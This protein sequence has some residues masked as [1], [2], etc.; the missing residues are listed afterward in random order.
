MPLTLEHWPAHLRGTAW[1]D[2][3]RLLVG[4]LLSSL[5]FEFVCTQL[6]RGTDLG[7]RWM[8]WIGILPA[9]LVFFIMR[10]VKEARCGS[11]ASNQRPT[12]N[13]IRCRCCASF[14]RLIWTTVHTSLLMGA[15][16]FM[17]PLDHLLV[18]ALIRLHRP[19]CRISR[20]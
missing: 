14:V 10:G 17:C 2:A 4:F 6:N 5:V 18:S 1:T 20:R 16:L 3:E 13:A 12:A 19:R 11:T 7:W 8:M 15:F 9:F